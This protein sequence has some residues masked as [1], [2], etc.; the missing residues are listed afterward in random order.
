[1][2]IVKLGQK[3]VIVSSLL[4]TW[5]V[6]LFH[7]SYLNNLVANCK[8][9][10]GLCEDKPKPNPDPKPNPNPDPKPN[11]NPKPNPVKCVDY[12][13]DCEEYKSTCESDA[14]FMKG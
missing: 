12:R 9:A 11:P 14:A 10:C 4:T 13:D 7:F 3:L 5:N 8:K 2:K 1:M 6:N